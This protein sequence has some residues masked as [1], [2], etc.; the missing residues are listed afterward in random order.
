MNHLSTA[1]VINVSKFGAVS[2]GVTDDRKA[3]NDALLYAAEIGG[4][5]VELNWT[6]AVTGTIEVP[7]FVCLRGRGGGGSLRHATR[8]V[9]SA[10]SG[11]V[12]SIKGRSARLERLNVLS[13]ESRRNSNT[14]TG[15]GIY[16]ATSDI[17]RGQPGWN[18]GWSRLALHDI[19]V[20]DQPTD[21][22]HSVGAHEL[23]HFDNVHVADCRR[24]G[25]V[26]GGGTMSGFSY[27]NIQALPWM[28]KVTNCRAIQCGG[29]AL[30]TLSD[31]NSVA[32]GMFFD[33]FEAL[34]CAWDASKTHRVGDDD[35]TKRYQIQ[36]GGRLHIIDRL[37]VEAQ[38]FEAATFS[39]GRENNIAGKPSRG[40]LSLASSIQVNAPFFSCLEQSWFQAGGGGLTMM[41]PTISEGTGTSGKS[42][43]YRQNPAM[44]IASSALGV[45]IHYLSAAVGGA[46]MVLANYANS[47]KVVV[48]G[49]PNGRI[50]ETITRPRKL[51][52]L[53]EG[54]YIVFVASGDHVILPTAVGNTS[55][56][57]VKNLQVGPV[58]IATTS[59]ETI[60]GAVASSFSIAPGSTAVLVSD[61][62]SWRTI[63]G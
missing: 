33:C 32:T 22:L 46:D 16:V 6:H 47:T 1:S 24:H 29:Q 51:G 43:G 5:V 44:R 14:L 63:Y 58:A 19:T 3:I 52:A 62:I 30:I 28:V 61:G 2:D 11:P 18:A 34:D 21:G 12:I 26:F 42:G 50:V 10:L 20:T 15:H 25:F 36:L 31:G 45:E 48:D 49:R 27:T 59:M 23:S 55:K 37:D 9:S 41:W 56:Y 35:N 53:A 40:V 57:T 60:D 13:T 4:G 38:R 7:R 8:V 17:A 54:D 39:S